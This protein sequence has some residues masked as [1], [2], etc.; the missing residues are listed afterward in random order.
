MRHLPQLVLAFSVSLGGASF[1]QR[2]ERVNQLLIAAN[3]PVSA[4]RARNEGASN[5]EVRG[6]LDALRTAR[7]PAHEARA[8]LDEERDA[9]RRNGP[10]DNFG[11][12]VQSKLQAGLRGRD[13]AA[14]IRAEH[15]ARG[16]NNAA[17][18]KASPPRGKAAAATKA[19]DKRP[20]VTKKSAGPSAT[21]SMAPGQKN[22]KP[23]APATKKPDTKARPSGR[24]AK[25]TL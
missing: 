6:A 13:L 1:A 18:S 22:A 9:R 3:L 5:D 19:A 10:V 2:S 16:K 11:A 12:F 8:V 20:Q 21:S 23:P 17:R 15:V 25:P 4:A 7:V 24:P 14:A